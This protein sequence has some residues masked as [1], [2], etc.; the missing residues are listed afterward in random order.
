MLLFCFPRRAQ[1]TKL[2]IDFD[3]MKSHLSDSRAAH[4]NGGQSKT[5]GH[6]L[7]DG[8]TPFQRGSLN[9]DSPG[10]SKGTIFT[11]LILMGEYRKDRF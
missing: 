7:E 1:P 5:V 4:N 8:I 3:K 2:V 6:G 11:A 9:H 10:S